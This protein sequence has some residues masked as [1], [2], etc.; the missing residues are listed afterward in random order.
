MKITLK[1][2]ID[3]LLT[4]RDAWVDEVWLLIIATGD[5]V[6]EP[7]IFVGHCVDCG[8]IVR[9]REEWNEDHCT[10]CDEE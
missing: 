4:E 1:E 10:A 5:H 3:A 8:R 9:R 7:N 6:D 2:C